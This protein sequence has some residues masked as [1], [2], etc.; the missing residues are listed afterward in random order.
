MLLRVLL[1][2]LRRPGVESLVQWLLVGSAIQSE[3]VMAGLDAMPAKE[4]AKGR[5]V[6][7]G[8]DSPCVHELPRGE[9][10]RCGVSDLH[11]LSFGALLQ[12]F[13]RRA[14]L[15][16]AEL[17][18]RAGLAT[19]AIGALERGNRRMPYLGTVTILSKALA[20]S[21]SEQALLVSAARPSA[22]R[23]PDASDI[24][25]EGAVAPSP[26]TPLLALRSRP[27]PIQLTPLLGR[28][29]E[30]IELRRLVSDRSV[31]LVT[32]TGIGG[33]GKTRLALAVAEEA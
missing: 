26:S 33:A 14:T 3:A 12:H 8:S 22:D 16:Q 1:R 11:G 15:T 9:R 17:A 23:P 18:V 19:S 29:A 2:L 30:L 13:R 6:L 5:R 20:L 31:R 10:S 27:L 25:V 24:S 7:H 4:Q 21:S 28:L 32:L